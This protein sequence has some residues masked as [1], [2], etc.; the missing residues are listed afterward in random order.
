MSRQ[1]ALE[2]LHE[3]TVI[4]AI[5]L[6]LDENRQ[7]D[8]NQQ[9]ILIRYYLECGVGGIAA[10]VHTTQFE[11]RCPG[12]DLLEPVLK[13]VSEEV[14]SYEERTGKTIVRVAGVCGPTQQA[15][16]ETLL[17]REYGYDV[18]LL[19]PGGLDG[20]TEEELVERTRAIA[21]VM[22]VIG[23]YLQEAVGG[24]V[25][26]RH[27]WEQICQIEQVVAIKCA[28]FNRYQTLDVVRAVACSER[29]EEI[30]LY[31]GND[32]HIV[33]DLLTPYHIVTPTGEVVEKNFEGGLLGH[34]SV[35]TR[36]AVDLFWRLK[37]A[38]RKK[39]TDWELLTLAEKITDA[40][41]AFFD[42]A[43][44]FHGCIAGICEVLRRQGL[45]KGCWCL[46]PEETLSEG[47]LEEIERVYRSYPELT[48]DQFVQEN[49][50]R[51]R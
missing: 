20:M 41:G 40:N 50:N 39:K 15:I 44:R 29:C 46:N 5:P 43:N 14:S 49:L 25:F 17:A 6:A 2:I 21:G 27:Y 42:A 8:Q 12:I 48:D 3:G 4:P 7:F 38:K 23:F 45:L 30:T 31:T 33:M 13:L 35:W 26:S 28:S 47:Q 36:S 1:K 19:S 24:R 10:A 32:D 16:R 22:P 18:V 9:R 11:I 34:W 51:W 37:D